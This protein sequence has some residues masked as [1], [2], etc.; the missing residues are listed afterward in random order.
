MYYTY[1]LL[2][3]FFTVVVFGLFHGLVY[4]PVVLS[5]LGPEPYDTS[6]V[7]KSSVQLEPEKHSNGH[8]ETSMTQTQVS[9]T[10]QYLLAQSHDNTW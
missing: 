3:V 10:I 9:N 4:L 6:S 1:P 5:W 8:V 7:R 2:Q